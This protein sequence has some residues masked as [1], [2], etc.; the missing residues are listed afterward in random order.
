[1]VAAALRETLAE[2]VRA[3][4]KRMITEALSRHGWN[5]KAAASELGISYPTILKKI[6]SFKITN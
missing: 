6:R 2:K 1:M 4:E 3:L 5:R